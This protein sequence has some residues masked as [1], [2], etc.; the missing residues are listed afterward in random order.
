MRPWHQFR[1]VHQVA[2]Q[3]SVAHA[4]HEARPHRDVLYFIAA[5]AYAI[6]PSVA[7]LPAEGLRCKVTT[8]TMV[9]IPT[10]MNVLSMRRAV[11]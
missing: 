3:Q 9:R 2:E 11:T 4:D 6:E 10:R 7:S 5:S 8:V 1:S